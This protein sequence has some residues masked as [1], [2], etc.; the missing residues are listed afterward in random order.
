MTLVQDLLIFFIS[1]FT[2]FIHIIL[3]PIENVITANIPAVSNAILY[4]G[5][6]ISW[7]FSF[8]TWAAS[9][10]PL[11]SSYWSIII[12]IWIFRLTVPLIADAIKLIVR[13]WHYLVP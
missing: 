7:L 11:S 1:C 13:W 10:L 12:S 8:I 2:G 9:W 3:S 6:F 5:N 4:V